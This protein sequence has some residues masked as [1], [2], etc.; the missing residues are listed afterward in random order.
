MGLDVTVYEKAELTEPHE[1]DDDCYE[2][3]HVRTFVYAG[4]EQS[5]RG[6]VGAIARSDERGWENGAE[7]PCYA[8]SGASFDFR[9]GSYSGHNRF[10]EKLSRAA[11]AV[12]PQT[13]WSHP[14]DYAE[15][16][17]FEFIN[18]ADNEGTIGPEAAADLA[19]DFEEHRDRIFAALDAGPDSDY[20]RGLYDDWAKAFALA[21]NTGLVEFH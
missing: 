16:P 17:F 10:R 12:E 11:L 2:K 6:L 3:N 7:P 19:R 20:F 15:R 14:E 8:T 4:F 21:A 18:F 9:A 1:Y 13:V 5:M